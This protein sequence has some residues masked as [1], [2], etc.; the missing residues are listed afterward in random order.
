MSTLTIYDVTANQWQSNTGPD[1]NPIPA[2]QYLPLTTASG[3]QV[4]CA[5]SK[6][7]AGGLVS[8]TAPIPPG[9]QFF[10]LDVAWI[11][12]SDSLAHTARTELDLKITF[13][14]GA[15]ANGSLQY[16][17]TK[18]EW[19][20]DPDGKG[21]QGTGYTDAPGLGYNLMQSRW[22][23]DGKI[24]SCLAL[25]LNGK[26]VFTPP[27]QFQNLPLIMTKWAAGLHAQLQKEAQNTP[28]FLLTLY[29]AVKISASDVAIPLS[30]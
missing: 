22:K 2:D 23:F 9:D 25:C 16:N 1:V 11:E 29:V 6:E 12:T 30:L 21:W 4:L 24:W 5:A 17:Y 27:A 26:N 28:W 18:G 15:Q 3:L 7:M 8:T 19:Q 10:G 13:P 14:G 20:L